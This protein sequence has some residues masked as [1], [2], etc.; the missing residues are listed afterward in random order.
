MSGPDTRASHAA[1]LTHWRLSRPLVNPHF[2]SRAIDLTKL[3]FIQRVIA[4]TVTPAWPSGAS[5]PLYTFPSHS[6]FS[7]EIGPRKMENLPEGSEA[8][9]LLGMLDHTMALFQAVILACRFTVTSARVKAYR[10]FI[11]DW[12]DS[13]H[14]HHPHTIDHGRRTNIHAA[15]HIYDFLLLFGPIVSWWCFPFEC[16]IGTLQRFKTNDMIGG[17]LEAT[18]TKSFTRAANLRRWLNRPDCPAIIAEFKCLFDL[19]YT[20]RRNLDEESAPLVVDGEHAHYTFHSNIRIIVQWY[21]VSQ[22]TGAVRLSQRTP[23]PPVVTTFRSLPR[24]NPVC[25][26]ARALVGAPVVCAQALLRRP[27]PRALNPSLQ[28]PRSKPLARTHAHNPLALAV[29]PLGA[30]TAPHATQCGAGWPA[31]RQLPPQDPM[32]RVDARH[33][34]LP[35]G[36]PEIWHMCQMPDLWDRCFFFLPPRPRTWCVFIDSTHSRPTATGSPCAARRR[37]ARLEACGVNARAGL[38]VP[39]ACAALDSMFPSPAPLIDVPS[40]TRLLQLADST[41]VPPRPHFLARPPIACTASPPP[42]PPPVVR[43]LGRPRLPVVANAHA[44]SSVALAEILEPPSTRGPLL[45]SMWGGWP[46]ATGQG[47]S[48]RGLGCRRVRTNS[49][50]GSH[51]ASRR[52]ELVRMILAPTRCRECLE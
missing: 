31:P 34:T 32:Q 40:P 7:G 20:P 43:A 25:A 19:A 22:G 12:V 26:L 8:Y 28:T 35:A 30:S 23:L 24:R 41:P 29:S 16:L 18:I 1:K 6:F 2:V 13:L 44:H 27:R 51:A 36:I 17:A 49:L 15:F 42:P 3:K 10:Q 52:T 38:D 9:C 39:L 47:I 37:S 50:H 4:N 5:S 11:K 33:R 46:A 21:S 48:W 14:E 45:D